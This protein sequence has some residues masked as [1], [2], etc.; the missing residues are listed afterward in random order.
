MGSPDGTTIYMASVLLGRI[1]SL[2]ELRGIAGK[3]G[4][5]WL[6]VWR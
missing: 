5:D 6:A 2:A 4:V 1:V 3:L